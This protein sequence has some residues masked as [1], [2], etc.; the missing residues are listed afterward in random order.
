M[1]KKLV[2]WDWDGTWTLDG[3]E[4]TF[5]E[6]SFLER[7][8]TRSR[9]DF[10]TFTS[11]IAEKRATVHR[12]PHKHG[13][14]HQGRY[15]VAAA[16]VNPN[17]ELR[18]VCELVLKAS[19]CCASAKEVDDVLDDAFRELNP[20]ITTTLRPETP[21]LIHALGETNEFLNCIVT[22]SHPNR[23]ISVV[24]QI[25]EGFGKNV[26]GSASK[27]YIDPWFRIIR[28]HSFAMPG[29]GRRMPLRRRKYFVIL[30]A[31]RKRYGLEWS[32]MCVVGDVLETD[33]LIALYMGAY[34]CLI[35]HDR[36]PAY[37]RV[38]MA[39]HPRAR[40]VSGPCEAI[41]FFK[42]HML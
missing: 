11:L 37:E 40:I 20:L 8:R 39:S 31:L 17:V 26:V 5:F 12:E 29:F 4:F 15:L 38:F 10:Q 9:L 6:G 1:K 41:L 16:T 13:W 23:V 35:D 3:V 21:E 25:H 24:S 18:A 14:R 28:D 42:E 7:I 2:V 34:V 30:D 27:G 33:L 22:N 32:D 36:V 19:R